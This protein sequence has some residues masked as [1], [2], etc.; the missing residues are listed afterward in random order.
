VQPDGTTTDLATKSIAANTPYSSSIDVTPDWNIG[1]RLDIYVDGKKADSF[2]PG[3]QGIN[4]PTELTGVTTQFTGKYDIKW[5][6][7]PSVGTT[8]PTPTSTTTTE[9]NTTTTTTEPDG[10]KKIQTRVNSGGT[11]ISGNGTGATNQDIYNDVKAA[12]TDAGNASTGAGPT[13]PTVDAVPG[14]AGDTTGEDATTAYNALK[15]SRTTLD[16]G[17]GSLESAAKA[18]AFHAPSVSA[19]SLSFPMTLPILGS[20]TISLEP[21]RSYMD[22]IRHLLLFI[23]TVGFSFTVKNIVTGTFK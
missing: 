6:D 15:A 14:V 5:N 4:L 19:S 22:D 9:G 3:T 12:V 18:N 11:T 21:Y 2:E 16:T 10:T 7:D 20:F 23:M 17:L 1:D 13:V 8:A